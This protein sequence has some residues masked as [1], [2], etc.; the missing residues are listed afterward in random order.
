METGA[1]STKR[2][3]SSNTVEFVEIVL[4][5][6]INAFSDSNQLRGFEKSINKSNRITPDAELLYQ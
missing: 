2:K 3:S 1:S 4:T 5:L 6:H